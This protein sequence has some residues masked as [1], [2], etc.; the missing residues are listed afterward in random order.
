[1]SMLSLDGD[2]DKGRGWAGWMEHVCTI[3]EMPMV[4]R[5]LQRNLSNTWQ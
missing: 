5:Y 4:S 2:L 3:R 1:M